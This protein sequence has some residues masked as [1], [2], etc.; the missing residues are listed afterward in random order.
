MF[1]RRQCLQVTKVMQVEVII[2]KVKSI[3]YEIKHQ[4]GGET[5][6]SCATV[7]IQARL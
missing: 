5:V 2:K 3:E 4:Y 6:C 7:K 1:K